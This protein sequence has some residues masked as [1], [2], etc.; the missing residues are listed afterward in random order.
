MNQNIRQIVLGGLL[1]T[2]VTIGTMV[3]KV[4][5]P[6]TNGYIHIGDS[7]IYL[8]AILFGPKLGFIAAGVGSALA[9][10]FSGYTHW[11]IPTFVIKGIEGLIIGTIAMRNY[12][13]TSIR[14]RDIIAT[15]IGGTWMVIGYFIAGTIMR[16]SWAAALGGI[17][18]N[19]TQA[20]GGMVIAFPIIFALLRANVLEIVTD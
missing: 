7:M 1:I 6:A 2:L 15:T 13:E 17:P 3:I 8:V 18:G 14:L 12:T 19:L 9:D 5:M 20:I 4:P 16:G 10:L 11:A